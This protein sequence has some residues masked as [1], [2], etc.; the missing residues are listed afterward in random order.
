MQSLSRNFAGDSG[1]MFS[2]SLTSSLTT[3]VSDVSLLMDCECSHSSFCLLS[4]TSSD[5]PLFLLTKEKLL[6]L[7]YIL[8]YET[9]G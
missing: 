2:I 4:L 7:P 8:L 3:L 5:L 9:E 6:L 1:K